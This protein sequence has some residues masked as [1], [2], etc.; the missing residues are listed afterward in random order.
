[1]KNRMPEMDAATIAGAQRGDRAAHARLYET[2]ASMVYTLAR[3]ILTSPA[4][5]E[6]VLQETF[7]EVICKIDSYRGDAGVGFWIRRIA[8]NKCLM[9][10]RSSWNAKRAD[11]DPPETPSAGGGEIAENQLA[12]EAALETISPTARVVVWLHDVEGYTHKEIAHLMGKT[13][14]FSKSQLARAHDKLRDHLGTE[15]EEDGSEIC[16]PAL[17]TC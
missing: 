8:V 9:Y 5:A 3:R 2:F 15:L 10:L 6:D 17:R 14:S 1:M 11:I 7:V 4:L 12:L 13:A 16:T